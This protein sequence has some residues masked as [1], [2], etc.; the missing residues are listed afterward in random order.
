LS[1]LRDKKREKV[2]ELAQL[3]KRMEELE[4]IAKQIVY[5]EYSY[6]GDI[7]NHFNSSSVNFQEGLPSSKNS[8]DTAVALIVDRE[9]SAASDNNLNSALSNLSKEVK[10]V[11]DKIDSVTKEINRLNRDIEEE[12]EAERRRAEEA[13]RKALKE[14]TDKLLGK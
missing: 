3:R 14:L 8:S 13:R 6:T 4:H 10:D 2:K 12:E 5:V 9:K 1:N 7:N 11:N